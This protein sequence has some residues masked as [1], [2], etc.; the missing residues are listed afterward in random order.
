MSLTE[1]EDRTLLKAEF[2]L[3][4]TEEEKK[5]LKKVIEKLKK[6]N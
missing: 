3:K 1:E 5:L 6:K 4:L 2:G